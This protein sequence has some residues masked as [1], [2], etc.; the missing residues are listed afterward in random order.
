[1]DIL[2]L[3]TI[4][5]GK[6]I[7]DAFAAQKNHVDCVDVY[8]G[9]GTIDQETAKKKDYDLIV[10]PEH[11]DPDHPLLHFS[12]APVISHHEAV[13][14]LLGEDIPEPMVEITGAQ[15]KTTT[16]HALA[17]LMEG[18]GI[19]HT[20]TGTYLFPERK[21][22]SKTSI[23][24]GSVLAA[25]RMALDINGWLIVEESLGVTGAGNLAIITSAGNYF[26]AAGKKSALKTKI[27]SAKQGKCL[28][29]A[30]N[31]DEEFFIPVVHIEDVT[32]CDGTECFLT[33]NGKDSRFSNPLLTLPGY[34]TP[35]RLAAAAAMMLGLDP[36]PLSAFTELPGRMSVCHVRGLLVID[37]ANS[38]T[39]LATTVEAAHYARHTSGDEAVTL[40][41]GQVEGD[42]AV[43]EG[44]AF[45]QIQ[46]AIDQI[47]PAHIVWVGAFP[48]PETPEYARLEPLIALHTVTLDEAYNAALRMTAHG[49]I[50]LAVK[51]WR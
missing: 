9:E 16:A 2:V 50:V 39:N 45:T 30:Q 49:S 40:V 14:R 33:M 28:L 20:S 41:I 37:N 27:A 5:G 47:K 6:V 38:G 25:A 34:H 26:F 51:T 11:L 15:G 10:A 42:G 13:R 31:I 43:C 24:P 1:M 22:I 8:R 29:L 17:F 46:T 19:L 18:N 36:A 7:G 35:L 12:Q 4:H 48:S 21:L 23:T 32:H 3:D 44:F